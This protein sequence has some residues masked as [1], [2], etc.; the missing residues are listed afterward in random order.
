MGDGAIHV[1]VTWLAQIGLTENIPL[2]AFR[3]PQGGGVCAFIFLQLV[4]RV[5]FKEKREGCPI[6]SSIAG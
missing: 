5:K 6:S 1:F 2:A 4:S 3:C